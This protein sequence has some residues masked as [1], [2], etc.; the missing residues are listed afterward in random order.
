MAEPERPATQ[1]AATFPSPPPFFQHFN[2]ENLEKI[3]ELRV[4]QKAS[5]GDQSDQSSPK[6]PTRLL[7]LPPELLFL[8]PP[9]PP[10]TGIYRV[11]GDSYTLKE[12]LPPLSAQ[13]IEQLYDTPPTTPSG[14]ESPDHL[15]L[16]LHKLIKSNFLNFLELI[17]ILGHNVDMIDEKTKD[18]RTHVVNIHHVLNMYRPHQARESLLMQMEDHVERANKEIEAIYAAKKRVEDEFERI[19]KLEIPEM[20]GLV[21]KEAVRKVEDDNEGTFEAWEELTKQFG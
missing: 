17:G 13:N 6:T 8:Q 18:L 1:L 10:S 16:I 4:A 9:L 2:V 15:N 21:K 7:N 3:N 19:S 12:I 14:S 5:T 11:F 20:D